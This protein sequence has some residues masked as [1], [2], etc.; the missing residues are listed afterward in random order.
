MP[1]GE[2]MTESEV[3]K[4][5]KR[6]KMVASVGDVVSLSMVQHG[7]LPHLTIYDRATERAPMTLLDNHL[8][9]MPG[10]DVKVPNPPGR[11]T[12]ELVSAISTA[13]HSPEPTK[14]LVEGE[15][16]LAGLVCA[17]LGPD[18]SCMVYGLPKKG[19]AFVEIDEAVRENAKRLIYSMEESK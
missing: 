4:A 8:K 10:I 13:M 18:G 15:E 1:F 7:L 3:V 19:L 12:P 11:I 16:D 14:L 6:C 9:N 2:Q 17:A 5:A